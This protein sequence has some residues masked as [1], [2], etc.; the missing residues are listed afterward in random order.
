MMV[1]QIVFWICV[2]IMFYSYVVYHFLLMVFSLISKSNEMVKSNE[3]AENYSILMSVYNEELV[4]EKK[5]ESIFEQSANES[6]KFEL[7]IGSDGSTDKTDEIILNWMKSHP[8]IVFKRF[9]KRTGK[10]SIIN[11]LM[12]DCKSDLVVLTDANVILEKNSVHE[13]LKHFADSKVGL[14]GGNIL[15][16]SNINKG[17]SHIESFYVN[18]ENQ[19]KKLESDVFKTM[20]GPFGG[21]YAFRK[22][23]FLPIP[24]H[25]LVDDF[26][27]CM[28]ILKQKKQSIFEQ[29]AIAFED[30]PS[31]MKVEFKRK[32]RI[33]TGNFQNLRRFPFLLNPF[34]IIGFC[35]ISHKLIRWMGPFILLIAYASNF[36]LAF[37]NQFYLFL[38]LMQSLLL[39]VFMILR[40]KKSMPEALRFITY[41]Y[42]MNLALL[43]G[44]V[45][46]VKGV[47]AGTWEPTK[48]SN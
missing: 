31:E 48:R 32:V 4:L 20:I 3:S 37:T 41:F 14:V 19:I 43:I 29:E 26:Y 39:I 44:F 1:F 25:F 11:E 6:R 45:Q 38:F 13:L 40:N 5:L 22:K 47:E 24:P 15:N 35:F 2:A 17:V 16:K 21:F 7:L 30:L 23:L 46:F 36:V 8:E 28:Q 18:R 42:N 27:W 9:E 12:K 10:P 33:G 34:S